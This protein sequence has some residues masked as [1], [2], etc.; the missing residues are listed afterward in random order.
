ML[1][2]CLCV[3]CSIITGVKLLGKIQNNIHGRFQD[4]TETGSQKIPHKLNLSRK[5]LWFFYLRYMNSFK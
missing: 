3:P 1:G 4:F 2:A 5:L